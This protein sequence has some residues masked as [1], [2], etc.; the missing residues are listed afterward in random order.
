[1]SE[2]DEYVDDETGPLPDEG[3]AYYEESRNCFHCGGDGWVECWDPI[4]CTHPHRVLGRT[5]FCPCASCGG[6]GLK[7]DMTIW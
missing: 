7:K 5:Q 3:G 2:P 1:M 4:Q 6:S